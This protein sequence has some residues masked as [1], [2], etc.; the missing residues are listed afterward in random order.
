MSE[1]VLV[2]GAA[3][4][5]GEPVARRLAADGHTVRVMSRHRDRV[6][7]RFG[8]GFEPVGA[9]AEDAASL[10]RA[11][12][13][14]TGI[15]INLS[16]G[17]DWDLERRG[18]ETASRVAAELGVRRITIISGASTCEQ[19]AWFPGT[20]AKLEAERAVVASGVPYTILRCTMF[21]ET[22]PRMVK[23]GRA[24]VMGHQPT[25]WHWIA[26]EDYARMVSAAFVTPGAAGK[27]LYVH[28]PEALTFEQAMRI[29]Q[30]ICAPE[31]EVRTIPFWLLQ[32]ISW[33]PGNEQLRRVGLPIM[34]YFTK[35]GEIGDPSEAN[36][37]LGAPA[38]TIRE[39]CS[40]RA[41][42]VA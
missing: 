1:T 9:D 24:M 28:G 8:E 32:L 36:D 31:A 7:E 19:N 4:M 39:W 29:Y 20:K 34:R 35:V 38:T 30:P 33:M 42:S 27:T 37:L 11:M 23:G 15:H 17:G 14:C 21:M 10:R 25:R 26:A 2:V 41:G 6:A 40:A 3:G 5:L 13:C 18:A 16:G 12:E 22:L